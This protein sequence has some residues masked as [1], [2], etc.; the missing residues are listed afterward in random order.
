MAAKS[1]VFEDLP[2][3][4]F[5]SGVPAIDHRRWRRVQ[6]LVKRLPELKKELSDLRTRIAAL[7]RRDTG[8]E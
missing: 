4:A 1:A 5:V 2:A 8:K 7:E 3:G 6:A